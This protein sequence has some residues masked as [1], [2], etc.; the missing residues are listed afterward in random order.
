M[1]WEKELEELERRRQLGRQMGG[2]DSIAFHHGRGKLTV[3]ER[4]DLLADENGFDE[5]G[6][7]SGVPE[8]DGLELKDLK[9]ANNVAGFAKIGGR[10]V[11]VT[12]GDFTIRGGSADGAVGN[13]A[14]YVEQYALQNNIPY[15]RLLDATGGSVRTFETMGRTYLPSQMRVVAPELLQKVPVVSA[16]LGSVAGLPAV[17]A[18]MCHFNVMVKNTSQVFV[19]GPPVVKTALGIEITK[20]D[21]GDDSVQVKKSGVICN[22][23]ETE[24]EA[25]QQIRQFLSYMP[26]NVW[27]APP[28][29]EPNDVAERVEEE[30]KD[31]IPENPRRLYDARKIIELTVDLGSFFEIQ[32]HF[33]RARIT[34]LARVNGYPV[35]VMSN[36]PKFMGGGLDIDTIGKMRRHVQLAD[37]FHMPMIYFCDEPGFMV[38]PEQER[39]GII[40][41]GGAMSAIINASRM[42]YLTFITRQCYGVAGGLHS[43]GYGMFRRYAWPSGNWGSMHIEG[44]VDAAYRREISDADDPDAKRA[45]IEARLN[46]LKS[47]FRTAH[48]FAIEDIIDPRETRLK[49]VEFVEDAQN[50]ITSQLGETSKLMYLP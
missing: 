29:E 44:G 21:L 50:I 47:P 5:I 15:V 19:G 6:V 45:E 37:I 1:A 35:C 11:A 9:P 23:T 22:V 26:Q 24:A 31:I 48:A 34:G 4:I 42:P 2:E 3:R 41:E 12:G 7:L 14:G 16:V 27:E 13:K 49:M 32:P 10:K 33:G 40:R 39:R 46:E 36:N 20:E 38:G 17:N 30:L 28:H 8:W 18:A 25:I 43:R